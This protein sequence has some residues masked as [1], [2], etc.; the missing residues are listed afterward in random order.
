MDSTYF[1][2][3][4]ME[5]DVAA[6]RPAPEP[7]PG[8]RLVAWNEALLDAHARTKFRAFRDEIDAQVFACLGASRGAAG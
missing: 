7:P 5:I 4:Q 8:Y 2:R 6:P 3:F 1:K